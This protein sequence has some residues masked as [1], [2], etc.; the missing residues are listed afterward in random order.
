[1]GVIKKYQKKYNTSN[2]RKI[3]KTGPA[4]IIRGLFFFFTCSLILIVIFILTIDKEPSHDKSR[5]TK[6]VNI[7]YRWLFNNVTQSYWN[8][9]K[10]KHSWDV[11]LIKTPNVENRTHK[12]LSFIISSWRQRYMQLYKPIMRMV[13]LFRI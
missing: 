13:V 12:Q 10:G 8:N 2:L 6:N 11:L 5:R 7:I 9:I 4:F 1:M 3:K